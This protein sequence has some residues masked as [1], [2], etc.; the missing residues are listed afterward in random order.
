LEVRQYLISNTLDLLDPGPDTATGYGVLQLTAPPPTP[1]LSPPTL[2]PVPDQPTATPAP[3][4]TPRKMIIPTMAAPQS[5]PSVNSSGDDSG[6]MI[7]IVVIGI[8]IGIL[9]SIGFVTARRARRE[10]GPWSRS[11]SLTISSTPAA[12]QYCGRSF[13]PDAVFCTQCGR[14]IVNAITLTRCSHCGRALRPGAQHCTR[15]GH[16]A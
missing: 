2:T 14:P 15:C 11:A 5:R 10:S 16:P 13:Q 4:N 1:T 6:S 9:G 7:G 3:T 8:A 12:C